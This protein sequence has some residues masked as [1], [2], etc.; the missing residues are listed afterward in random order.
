[1]GEFVMAQQLAQ[2]EAE[3]VIV[4]EVDAER[5]GSQP[6]SAPA[7]GE[8]TEEEPDSVVPWQGDPIKSPKPPKEGGKG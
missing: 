1:M 2:N 8:G 5:D 3:E 7:G 6:S 4:A